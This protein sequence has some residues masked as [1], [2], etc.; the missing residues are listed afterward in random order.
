VH[1]FCKVSVISL[2][3]IC[4][5]SCGHSD[6][7]DPE[8]LRSEF[9][10]AISLASEADMFINFVRNGQATGNYTA[11]HARQLAEL[12]R[13]SQT[14]L[15]Q[16][17]NAPAAPAAVRTCGDNLESLRRVVLEIPH[18]LGDPPA[19]QSR[20]RTI[21]QIQRQLEQAGASL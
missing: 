6:S 15:K 21:V 1:I 7:T 12:I 3:L 5:A 16:M 20:A 8:S 18:S 19:L 11:G 4:L 14:E 9:R 10:S 17:A 13:Q 2:I